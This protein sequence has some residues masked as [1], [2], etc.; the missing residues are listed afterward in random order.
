MKCG[1]GQT[2]GQ[3]H[4][5]LSKAQF[6]LVWWSNCPTARTQQIARS[7]WIW[8]TQALPAPRPHESCL[9]IFRFKT[10][11]KNDPFWYHEDPKTS[12]GL[13][14]SSVCGWSPFPSA[15]LQCLE[16]PWLVAAMRCTRVITWERFGHVMIKKTTM[17]LRAGFFHVCQRWRCWACEQVENS[18]ANLA[19]KRKFDRLWGKVS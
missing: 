4:P 10:C 5:Q 6:P 9:R 3:R 7:W 12:L 18:R 13:G 1:Q 17:A 8:R 16:E 15:S 11:R 14:F 19:K 2:R